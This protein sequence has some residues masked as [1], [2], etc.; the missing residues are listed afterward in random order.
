V[1]RLCHHT[2]R[3]LGYVTPPRTKRPVYF[4]GLWPAN[5]TEPPPD[6]HRQYDQWVAAFVARRASQAADRPGPKPLIEELWGAYQEWLAGPIAYMKHGRKTSEPA[7]ISA[8]CKIVSEIFGDKVAEHFGGRDLAAVREAFIA[9]KWVRKTI[10][11]NLKRV[12]GMF[13]WGVAQD[14]LP[15]VVVERLMAVKGVSKSEANV[16]GIPIEEKIVGVSRAVVEATLNATDESGKPFVPAV[17]A[18][19]VRVHWQLGCRAEDVVLLRTKDIDCDADLDP[20]QNG[21]NWLWTPTWPETGRP[22]SKTEHVEDK[23]DQVYWI[24]PLCQ[25]LLKPL[26]DF[27]EKE[28]YLFP[29]PRRGKAP[30][31]VWHGRYSTGSYRKAITRCIERINAHRAEKAKRQGKPAELLPAWTPLLV[32]HGRLTEVRAY[33]AAHGLNGA[34][35]AQAISGHQQLSTAEIYAEKSAKLARQIM[36]EL[37]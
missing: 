13:R 14:L 22:T 21:R 19:M 11:K 34:E 3:Q 20:G 17:L 6:I 36:R 27:E 16:R 31:R 30:G 28:R 33:A 15:P 7:S 24:G 4:E 26:L 5:S 35:A 1:P 10:N 9:K 2:A 8:A 12:R 18:T 23:P 32:R 37:G 25:Q 29:T